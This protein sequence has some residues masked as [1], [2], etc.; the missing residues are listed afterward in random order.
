M[1]TARKWTVRAALVAIC[2]GLGQLWYEHVYVLPKLE[3]N[4]LHPYT[5]WIPITIW[6]LLRNLTPGLDPLSPFLS[7]TTMANHRS[8]GPVAWRVCCC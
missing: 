8:A 2:V 6:I 1:P 5:S 7:V 4:R 3:Y